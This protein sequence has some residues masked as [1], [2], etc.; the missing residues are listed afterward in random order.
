M[1]VDIGEKTAAS[2][3]ERTMAFFWGL[4]KTEY[5]TFEATGLS[6]TGSALDSASRRCSVVDT[7]SGAVCVMVLKSPL[8]V[9]GDGLRP[10][11]C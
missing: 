11:F 2:A 1:V 8:I 5:A 7:W 6:L 4:V 10:L 9:A 3:A